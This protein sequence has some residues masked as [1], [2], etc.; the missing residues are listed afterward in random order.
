MDAGTVSFQTLQ[1]HYGVWRWQI[2][3][4]S[5]NRLVKLW[6]EIGSSSLDD[7]AKVSLWNVAWALAS[8]E[9]SYD[10]LVE[11]IV[12]AERARNVGVPPAMKVLTGPYQDSLDYLLGMSLWMDLGDV[13]VAYRTIM[14]RFGLLKT[15][16]RRKSPAWS[17]ADVDRERATLE[18]RRLPELSTDSMRELAVTILH[19][20]W[21]PDREPSLAFRLY[22][23]GDDRKTL[24]FAEDNLRG[25]LHTLVEETLKQVDEFILAVLQPYAPAAQG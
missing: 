16:A 12:R 1:E 11:D 13:L 23:K 19:V 25:R 20:T 5:S 21:H 17:V 9:R 22:W 8:F 15:P 6:V 4:P 3:R 18:A 10:I 14:D 2:E 7:D 24:D